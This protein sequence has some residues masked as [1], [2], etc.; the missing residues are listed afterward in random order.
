MSHVTALHWYG[1]TVG[2]SPLRHYSTNTTSQ[3]RLSG[4]QLHRRRGRLSSRIVHGV[5]VLGPDRTLVDCATQLNPHDLVRAGDWLVRLGLTDPDVL[6]TYAR[7]RHL[8]GVVLARRTT[9]LVRSRVDSVKETDVRLVL[10]A[11]GLPEPEVNG[12]IME[13]RSRFLARGDLVYH[14]LRIVIEYDGWHHERSADQR[15]RDILRRERL[16]AAGWR[17]II[18]TAE[19]LRHVASLVGRIWD[20][21]VSAGYRG[22][23][24][25][26]DSV[27]LRTLRD[28]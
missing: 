13:G 5:P 20:A 8:D 24:P 11:S 19:D 3:T 12:T 21:M 10:V 4:V 17:V 1:V 25:R 23:A 16:E 7:E 6:R 26:L 28:V 9:P 22:P 27:R 14:K 15:R 18:V 2:A